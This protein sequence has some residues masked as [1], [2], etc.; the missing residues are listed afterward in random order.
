[1]FRHVKHLIVD[2]IEET[3]YKLGRGHRDA[4]LDGDAGSTDYLVEL[5]SQ[6]GRSCHQLCQRGWIT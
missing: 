6:H 4:P 5:N 3:Y 1:M 2:S